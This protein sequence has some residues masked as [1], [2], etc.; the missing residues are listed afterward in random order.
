MD[1]RLLA[2]FAGRERSLGELTALTG[3]SGFDV[4]AVHHAD[5][6]AITELIAR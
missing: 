6:I 1:L 5:A 2:Y 3:M 4:V